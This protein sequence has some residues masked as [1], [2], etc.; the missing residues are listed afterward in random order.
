MANK[1]HLSELEQLLIDTEAQI[2][3]IQEPRWHPVHNPPPNIVNFRIY[4]NYTDYES[5]NK[6]KG[7]TA[8]LVREDIESVQLKSPDEKSSCTTWARVFTK[9]GSIVLASCYFQDNEGE[10]VQSLQGALRCFSE[11]VIIGGDFNAHHPTWDDGCEAK[12]AEGERLSQ[13]IEDFNLAIHTS[14]SIPTHYSG[15]HRAKRVLDLV[16]STVDLSV[17]VTSKTLEHDLAEAHHRP[18]LVTVKTKLLRN[19]VYLRSESWRVHAVSEKDYKEECEKV[20]SAKLENFDLSQSPDELAQ[21]IAE[22]VEQV[23]SRTVPRTKLQ[24]IEKGKRRQPWWT[25]KI[26]RLVRDSRKAR[27]YMEQ[28][29]QST[30]IRKRYKKIF[31]RKPEEISLAQMEYED[32]RWREFTRK[33][34]QFM[35]DK[36]KETIGQDRADFP[37]MQEAKTD[38]EKAQ[39]LLHNYKGVSERTKVKGHFDDSKQAEVESYLR[40]NTQDFGTSGPQTDYNSKLRPEELEH[41]LSR[42]KKTAV[43]PDGIPNWAY[44]NASKSLKTALLTL[45]NLSFSTGCFPDSYRRAD[46]VSLPK[47][48]KDR[49]R[50]ENYRPISLTNTISRLFESIIHKR[51]YA[52]CEIHRILPQSQFAYRKGRSS[53]DPLILITQDIKD[54][55]KRS[56]TTRM[57]QLDIT[58]AFDTV[59]LEGL[60]YKL[61]KIGLRN[62][63]LKWLS[64]YI[65]SRKYRVITPQVTGYVNFEDGVPQGSCLSPL[66]FTIFLSDIS[67][68]LLCEHAEF[69]DDFTL[70]KTVSNN[71]DVDAIKHDLK[72]IEEWSSR[73]RISF[74]DKC[75]HTI[76]KTRN[77]QQF[78]RS[79]FLFNGRTLREEKFPKLLGLIF[80]PE[81]NFSKHI[82]SLI[83]KLKQKIGIFYKIISSK[84]GS[85]TSA[86]ISIYKGW[87]R[88]T[89]ETASILYASASTNLLDK[90]EVQQAKALRAILGAAENTPRII[91]TTECKVSSLKSRRDLA[92]LKKLRKI[93][94]QPPDSPLRHSLQ[95]WYKFD[96]FVEFGPAPSGKLSFF[97]LAFNTYKSFFGRSPADEFI[98][99]ANLIPSRPWDQPIEEELDLHQEFRLSIR[100][101]A[102]DLQTKLYSQAPSIAHYRRLKPDPSREWPHRSLSSRKLNSIL[103]KLRSGFCNVGA[104]RHQPQIEPCPGCAQEDSIEHFLL[105]CPKYSQQR[106]K[107]EQQLPEAVKNQPSLQE[108]LGCPAH[109]TG[110][111]LKEVAFA[112][113]KFVVRSRRKI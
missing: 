35:W 30:S 90:L 61:H 38:K 51:L 74:G 14:P 46:I 17:F 60:R 24:K 1:K 40:E 63:L 89:A 103:F 5:L 3:L 71:E 19:E 68:D 99:V 88:P 25:K 69:A 105:R 81:L 79:D 102:R 32:R 85:V 101:K 65:E 26:G 66:L 58:K 8:I 7:G 48:G 45:F 12:N 10:R 29:P 92:I 21:E 2:A 98:P 15:A 94:T 93:Q 9:K 107:L 70:W 20:F 53:I 18:Q 59:W 109:L 16:L 6:K 80:D 33:P 82:E 86:L 87:I 13:I 11:K 34:Q 22:A 83:T 44:K 91:L 111:E 50:P 49:T 54:G 106:S 96:Y 31:R 43:G 62:H 110:G 28:F 57:V 113:T 112:V 78:P 36:V 75:S 52:F 37:P 23:L 39:K 27:R 84:L 42:L 97:G 55:F 100:E 64:S 95:K 56:R 72:L 41:A 77:K 108:L 47:A 76:F 73:W 67:K 104:A 4:F